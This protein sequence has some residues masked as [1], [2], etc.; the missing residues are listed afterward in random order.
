MS[1]FV[2]P[3]TKLAFSVHENR[4]V[5]ALL[6]GSG[7]SR[8]AEIM[9]GWEI[10]LDLVRRVAMARGVEEKDDWVDWYVKAEGK[11]PDYSEVLAQ[12]ASFKA[13]R[14]AILHSY[15]EPSDKDR[16]EGRKTP[17]SAHGAI[18]RL[19]QQGYVRVIVTTNFDRLMET[20]LREIGIEP[21][22]ITSTD[23]LKGADP[24]THC[25]CYI[26]KLHGDYKD[27]RIRNTD[28]ELN[29]YPGIYNKLLHR[30]FDE[31]GLI[32]C[33]WSGEWDDALRSAIERVKNRR[34]PMFWAS[35]GALKGKAEDLCRARKGIAVSISDADSFF[36][37]LVEQVE[38]LARSQRQNPIGVEMLVSRAKRYLSKPEH[39]IQLEDLVFEEVERV[40]SRLDQDDVALSSADDDKDIL[41][42]FICCE[43]I[44]EGLA[45]VCGLIGRWGNSAQISV[46]IDSIRAILSFAKNSP[47]SKAFSFEQQQYPAVLAY[48]ACTLGLQ[49]S[50]KWPE[51]HK[52]MGHKIGGCF[53]NAARLLEVVGPT[54]WKNSRMEHWKKLPGLDRCHTPLNDHL[55]KN[56]FVNWG[57]AFLPSRSPLED[58]TV[59]NEALTAIRYYEETNIDRVR[60]FRIDLGE[61]GPSIPM[62]R[63]GRGGEF[64]HDIL[65]MIKET[66][67][68]KRLAD[69]GFG[70]GD[71]EDISRTLEAHVKL[72]EYEFKRLAASE[73]SFEKPR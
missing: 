35:R 73:G 68:G 51:L 31:H 69:A 37:N 15:I 62:G 60:F 38:A 23:S 9:T 34:Y 61:D 22:V 2:D 25:T 27:A 11:E 40:T 26:L 33:G 16:E 5:F 72:L 12:V 71:E 66:D 53:E 59:M 63:V 36:G 57:K 70:G 48:H 56:V 4:G 64:L 29:D 3:A 17:T 55:V 54:L 21:T 58:M 6:L 43:G 67:L 41:Q 24:F 46:V 18:A 13:E 32:V 10:T 7:L 39:R 28:K 19:V 44:S 65:P 20:A 52:F 8:A 30:I 1:S 42:R 47:S 50:Q 14:R 49:H 45:K